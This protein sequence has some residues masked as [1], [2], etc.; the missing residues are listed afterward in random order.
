LFGFLACVS[1]LP[2]HVNRKVIIPD[3]NPVEVISGENTDSDFSMAAGDF[4][5]LYADPNQHGAWDA[6]VCCFFLDASPSVIQYIQIIYNMLKEGGVLISFGPLLYHWSGPSLRPDDETYEAYQA[7]FG[8][9]DKRYMSSV[10]YCWQDVREIL[11]NAGF[12]IEEERA[13]IQ[14]L[15]TADSTSMM[16]MSY[17]CRHFVARKGSTKLET[18]D[19]E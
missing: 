6:V 5:S 9:L 10:D 12:V 8:H 14:S 15:Y 13:G 4:A 7:R 2:N 16:N 11:I 19:M 18:K 1:Q 17:R 3:V